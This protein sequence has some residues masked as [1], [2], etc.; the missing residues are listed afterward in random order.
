M[1]LLVGERLEKTWNPYFAVVVAAKRSRGTDCRVGLAVARWVSFGERK[2]LSMD[3]R[4]RTFFYPIWPS[5]QF[6]EKQSEGSEAVDIYI[7]VYLSVDIYII[8]LYRHVLVLLRKGNEIQT[9]ECTH[10]KISSDLAEL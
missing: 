2:R 6:E 5:A 10:R 8:Q 7:Y 4:A 9:L 1:D 3:L